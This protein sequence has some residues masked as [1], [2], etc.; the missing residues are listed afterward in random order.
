[1][2]QMFLQQNIDTFELSNQLLSPFYATESEIVLQDGMA[3]KLA[4]DLNRYEGNTLQINM[5]QL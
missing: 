4:S 1:M 5:L 3:F 2:V